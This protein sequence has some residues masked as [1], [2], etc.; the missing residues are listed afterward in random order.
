M[1]N[2]RFIGLQSNTILFVLFLDHHTNASFLY[3]D[4]QIGNKDMKPN[5]QNASFGPITSVT[6][7]DECLFD[8]IRLV[9]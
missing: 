1:L 6:K 2:V 3:I 7:K 9:I 8:L 5:L 4:I